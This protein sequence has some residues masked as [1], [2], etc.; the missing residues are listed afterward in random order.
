MNAEQIS[1]ENKLY[2]I[3]SQN[4]KTNL[5]KLKLNE[6]K[7]KTCIII[8]ILSATALFAVILVLYFL[9]F[10]KKTKPQN[11]ANES[12]NIEDLDNKEIIKHEFHEYSFTATYKSKNGKNVKIFNPER[13]GLQKG[14]YFVY[15]A[16]QLSN[17]RRI[18][19]SED[20][21][22]EFNS[23]KDGYTTIKVNF[24]NP[25]TNLDFMF[26]GC[27]DLVEVNL[28]RIN[29]SL[30]SMIY[31]FTNCINLQ[32]VDLES[33]DT[34]NVTSMDFLFAGCENLLELR[35][36]ENLNTTSLKKT[37]GMFIDCTNLRSVNLSNLELDN[38]EEPS[39]IFIKILLFI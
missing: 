9:L 33:V 11:N 13:L 23:T 36:F 19:E 39:G 34:S 10:N 28:S 32:Q 25:L 16:T 31:T 15:E 37:S 12:E 4:E 14:D 38:I 29:S 1:D 35:G 7:R 2:S 26:D 24:T 30:D 6:S 17:L 8:S 5:K 18:E 27:E 21:N 22:G 3:S 20:V